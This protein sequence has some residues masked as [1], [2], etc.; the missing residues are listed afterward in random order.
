MTRVFGSIPWS[1]LV[2]R[3]RC[4]RVRSGLDATR[5]GH[6]HPH[7]ILSVAGWRRIVAEHGAITSLSSTDA[8][9]PVDC[10]R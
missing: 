3:R 4:G 10:D 6:V 9:K 7:V 1:M 5:N 8:R 2:V